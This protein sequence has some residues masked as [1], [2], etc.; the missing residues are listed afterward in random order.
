M[1]SKIILILAALVTASLAYAAINYASGSRSA[2]KAD[3][4]L[5]CDPATAPGK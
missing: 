1:K 5:C 3:D 4:A 2:A